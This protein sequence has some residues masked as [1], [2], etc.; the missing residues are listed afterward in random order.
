MCILN[1]QIYEKISKQPKNKSYQECLLQ[2]LTNMQN[3]TIDIFL[4]NF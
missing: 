2:K 1:L 3:F 4:V